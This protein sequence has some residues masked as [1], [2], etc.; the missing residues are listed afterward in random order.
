MAV[1]PQIFSRGTLRPTG[2]NGG[3]ADSETRSH[4]RASWICSFA[5]RGASG[6]RGAAVANAAAQQ[7]PTSSAQMTPPRSSTKRP[8]GVSTGA[9]GPAVAAAT[10][11]A[12]AAAS[13]GVI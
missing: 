5:W 12:A 7:Q 11:A 10:V 9:G 6:D 3:D 13:V 1:C 2:S 4:A 8:K